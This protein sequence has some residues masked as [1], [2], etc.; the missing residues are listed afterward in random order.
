M[1]TPI[2][3]HLLL[4]YLI[5]LL[6][7]MGLAAVLTWKAVEEM[8]LA[9]QRENLLAQASLTATALQD[10]GYPA[11]ST[12]PY[13]QT[14]NVQPG[15]HTHI[16]DEQGAVA[17][18]LPLPSGSEPVQVPLAE[19]SGLVTS[20]ELAARQEIRQALAGQAATAIRQVPPAAGRRVLYATAPV[21]ANGN[22]SGIVYVAMPLPAAGLPPDLIW[23]LAGVLLAALLLT[24]TAGALL[25]RRIARPLEE[26]SQA[27]GAVAAGDLSK[28]VAT[29][30][31][32]AELRR[33][34]QAFNAMTA[35]LRQSDQA[36]NAFI[37]D[38]T[39]ELRTPLTVIKGTI[40]TLEDGAVDDL[41][42]RGPLLASM[43]HETDRLI[44]L[45]SDLLVLTRAD[46]GALQLHIQ[47]LDVSKAARSRCDQLA[48][49]A[50]RRQVTLRVADKG[51]DPGRALA[52]TDRV[53]Q[54]LS[55]LLDNAIRHAPAG[56]TVTVT[57]EPA[58]GEIR[59]AVSDKGPG[60][61]A[62]HLPL[63]FERFYR[64]DAS[65][66]RHT[67]GLGLGLAIVK[68]LVMAQ[69]GRVGAQSIEGQ[70][71]TITFWLPAEVEETA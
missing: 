37:A 23:Q 40:E 17:L 57:V 24:G 20:A 39:H 68:A 45:V 51:P 59:C 63:V 26:M 12:D 43:H 38:V 69:G 56:S 60:I 41:D 36:K 34:G 3:F 65:R 66:N 2:R 10:A 54:V 8:Y 49:L 62:Q 18:S 7:G 52:D 15:I 67:G 19:S 14:T 55:N 1:T 35:A 29:S 25:A 22:V 32:I 64:V 21:F 33:L 50:A 4:G 27:A 71:A 31:N 13:L 47:P 61:P 42:G 58:Q 9:T 53:A 5:A 28:E 16:L 48:P 30:R 70:G 46:A 44:R 6:A 11:G